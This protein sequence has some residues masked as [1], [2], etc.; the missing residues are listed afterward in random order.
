MTTGNSDIHFN[1]E[2]FPTDDV[3][4]LLPHPLTLLHLE[5]IVLG[6]HQSFILMVTM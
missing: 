1:I 4:S 2:S 3:L 6:I 5:W